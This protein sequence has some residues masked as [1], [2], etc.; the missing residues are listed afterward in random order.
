MYVK[1]ITRF[2]QVLKTD[3]RKR[4]LVPVFLPHRVL[5]YS[6]SVDQNCVYIYFG[7]QTR[8]AVTLQ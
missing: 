2:C 4:K 5:T 6:N 3:A 1:K 8:L 7:N